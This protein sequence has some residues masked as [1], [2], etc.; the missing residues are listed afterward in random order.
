MNRNGWPAL[1]VNGT[2][3]YNQSEPVGV[4]PGDARF[5]AYQDA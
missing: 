3:T 5:C 4:P 1:L 2:H